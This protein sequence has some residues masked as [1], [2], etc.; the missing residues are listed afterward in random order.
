MM[1]W[2]RSGGR[3]SAS[4]LAK[5]SAAPPGVDGA[6]I[7]MGR[8]GHSAA[9]AAQAT[10]TTAKASAAYPNLPIDLPSIGPHPPR[11]VNNSPGLIDAAL[12]LHDLIGLTATRKAVSGADGEA[13]QVHVA[14][15]PNVWTAHPRIPVRPSWWR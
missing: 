14:R 2:C 3:Y 1:G 6:M 9:G 13:F 5:V 7:L 8:V 12:A 15:L 10:A 11:Y 4:S